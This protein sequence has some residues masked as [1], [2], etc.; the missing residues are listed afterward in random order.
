GEAAGSGPADR[1]LP[2]FP[3]TDEPV[4]SIVI[5][6]FNNLGHTLHCLEALAANTPGRLIEVIVVD[7]AS[8]DGTPGVLRRV[9]GI[10]VLTG[11]TNVG[12][13]GAAG[14][15]AA[16]ARGRVV[17]FLNND[18]EVQPGWLEAML[19]AIDSAPDVGAVGC[20]LVFAD[21]RLQEAGGIIWQDGTGA[22]VGR[23]GDPEAPRHN[24][25]REVDYC[26]GAALMVRRDLF[27]GLGGFD[28][29]FAP[30]Y[31]EDT[32]LC[33]ALRDSG[34]RV[35]YE[36]RATVVHHEGA[37]HG[38]DGGVGL[39]PHIKANQYVNRHLF[40]DKWAQ[41][42]QRHL[43]AGTAAGLLGGRVDRA[44]RVLVCDG[45]LPRHDRDSGGLRMSWIVRLLRR[46]GCEVTLVPLDG[47]R[48]EP[49]VEEFQRQGIEV[50][51]GAETY[52][53]L[54]RQRPCLYDLVILSR[55][56]VARACLEDT[57]RHLPTAT[58]VYDAVD[59]EFVREQRRLE[60]AGETPSDDFHRA[61]R[62]ELDVIRAC[63]LVSAITDA[64]ASVILECVPSARTL[65]LPN[66]HALDTMP[67]V[68]FAERADLV[69]LGSYDHA[70]NVDCVR[71]LAAEVMP[72]VRRRLDARLWLLGSNPP[73]A[74]TALHGGDIVVTGH[75]PDVE[76]H[77]RQARV[78]V[79]PLRYGAGMKGKNGH[80][81]AHGLPVVTSTVGAEGMGLEDG[82]HALIRDDPEAF[83]GA[84]VELYT[85][86]PMWERISTNALEL[87]RS[88]WTPEAM[89]HRL[90]DLLSRTVWLEGG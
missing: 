42:L 84:I 11:E 39:A 60:L 74:V 43:P 69:F 2:S 90:R 62:R 71:H 50:L 46:L 37:T 21:G 78:F 16:A 25:R 53:D 34:F 68:G 63:D 66:V 14:R 87:V 35:L 56:D 61:R 83:A 23:G 51:H 13:T 77:L 40:T 1:P 17:V 12:F 49:Y 10:E 73:A 67:A 45:W 85:Q 75:V 79:A 88:S 24:V 5:P 20:R 4:A 72:L 64:E 44:P 70:P 65:L 59:L 81:M 86:Q 18:T 76:A 8:T 55:P 31:Y 57:R 41:T 28:P 58:V 9:E 80:A 22:N 29:R 6:V 36:P 48:R 47:R 33:F 3:R 30:A 15:G 27:E 38:T 54:V 52:G 82:R 32:D 7:D 19:D 26:S 89:Q